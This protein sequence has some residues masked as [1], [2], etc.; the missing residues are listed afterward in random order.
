MKK[1]KVDPSFA[2]RVI[3]GTI[4]GTIGGVGLFISFTYS[5]R[6]G[7]FLLG[8]GTILAGFGLSK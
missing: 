7:T 3:G 5:P 2:L 1:A 6:L 4:G 8:V